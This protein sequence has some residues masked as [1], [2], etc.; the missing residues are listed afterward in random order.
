MLH[1]SSCNNGFVAVQTLGEHEEVYGSGRSEAYRRQKSNFRRLVSLDLWRSAT[2]TTATAGDKSISSKT[3][4]DTNEMQILHPHQQLVLQGRRSGCSKPPTRAVAVRAQADTSRRDVLGSVACS[5]V[6]LWLLA[7]QQHLPAY[8]DEAPA[9]VEEAVAEPATVE[10]SSSATV[11]SSTTAAGQRQVY[12]DVNVEGKP[13]G[14]IVIALAG[15]AK[16]GSQRF[17][18]LAEG[19]EGV[20]Y[21]L[22]KFDGIF[23][24]SKRQGRGMEQAAGAAEQ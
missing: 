7:S 9:A 1:D 14:R 3:K 18:D 8:A 15:D 10:S 24:V 19:K 16:V 4:T 12:L 6:S 2:G 22:S 13:L 21:R 23:P 5:T 20:G 11:S 17:A